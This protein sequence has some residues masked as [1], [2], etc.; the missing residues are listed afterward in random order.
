MSHVT[1]RNISILDIIDTWREMEKCVELGLCK[2]IAVSNFSSKQ[3]EQIW[4]NSKIKPII[5]QVESYA[6][7][8]NQRLNEYCI[9]KGN[10]LYRSI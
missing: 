4:K 7:F 2:S 10:L 3:L 5:N 8:N 1:C 9:E 6:Y